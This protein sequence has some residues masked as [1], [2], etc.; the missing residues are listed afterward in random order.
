MS[1]LRDHV[2]SDCLTFYILGSTVSSQWSR[3][4]ANRHFQYVLPLLERAESNS[5]LSCPSVLLQIMLSASYLCGV[6]PNSAA[7]EQTPPEEEAL[8]LM[9]RAQAF[10]I[11]A[12]AQVVQ[13]ISSHDDF[14]SRV[15]VASAHKSAICL[16]I[17]RV[18]P[19]A[20]L[21]NAKAVEALVDDTIHHLSCI[22]RGD[23]LIKGTAW[24]TFVAGA[25]SETSERRA[26]AAERLMMLWKLM[27]WG[28]LRT[29]LETLQVVWGVNDIDPETPGSAVGWLQKLKKLGIEWM[30][31]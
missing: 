19:S 16:Y 18:V 11:H 24:P 20:H 30:V 21:L 25:E 28:Y 2:I 23:S 15:H 26:W 31:V 1:R 14:E 10:D 27:L 22:D 9:R 4:S 29:A 13:G 17:H 5:Y 8:M 7:E 3:T 12:W 6:D